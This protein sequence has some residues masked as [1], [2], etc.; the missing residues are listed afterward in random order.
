ML[1]GF[2]NA[3]LQQYL[4]TASLSAV[5]TGLLWVFLPCPSSH[6]NLHSCSLRAPLGQEM[7]CNLGQRACLKT[8]KWMC[9]SLIFGSEHWKNSIFVK[10]MVYESLSGCWLDTGFAR[11]LLRA[12][13]SCL[14]AAGSSVSDSLLEPS[15]LL[16]LLGLSLPLN[17]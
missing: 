5:I 4:V 2:P 6:C 17:S 13:S 12:H 11:G 14:C 3:S 15:L 1:S 9:S 8:I 10:G 16:L 7:C